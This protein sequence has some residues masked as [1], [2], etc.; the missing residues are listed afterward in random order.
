MHLLEDAGHWVCTAHRTG[1]MT[2]DLF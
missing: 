1:I 2:R